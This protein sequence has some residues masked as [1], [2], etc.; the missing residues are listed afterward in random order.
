[1]FI[2]RRNVASWR[3]LELKPKVSHQSSVDPIS[4]AIVVLI[5][6][7]FGSIRSQTG[8]AFDVLFTVAQHCPQVGCKKLLGAEPQVIISLNPSVSAVAVKVPSQNV[9]LGYL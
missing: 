6:S 9:T 7:I 1:M 2:L 5:L 4:V 8:A 3:V